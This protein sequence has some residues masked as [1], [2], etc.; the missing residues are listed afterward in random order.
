MVP[1]K[2]IY[3]F[4]EPKNIR[5]LEDLFRL[6]FEGFSDSRCAGL[7]SSGH[8][9]LEIDSY[10]LNA[11][12]LGLF[13]SGGRRPR[14]VGYLRVVTDEE[15][16]FANDI[17]LIAAKYPGLIE[18]IKEP[19]PHLFPLLAYCDTDGHITDFYQKAKSEGKKMAEHSRFVFDPG[20]RAMGLHRFFTNATIVSSLYSYNIHYN[21]LACTVRHSV[22]YKRM[23]FKPLAEGMSY[24][25]GE[26][27]ASV[28]FFTK[29]LIREEL[30]EEAPKMARA[31]QH[32]GGLHFIPMEKKEVGTP[33]KVNF[34]RQK[35]TALAI[36][37]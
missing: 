33:A 29:N 4:R 5:E 25:Y 17:W 15:T 6:R 35:K 1:P 31:F 27:D 7:L 14:A 22:Y 3:T 20:I 9:G 28:L 10:D 16:H 34:I 18:K 26:F 32:L 30:Q 37:V 23:G 12:H 11:I 21:M 2:K 13:E 24:T 36:A 8:Y 19:A